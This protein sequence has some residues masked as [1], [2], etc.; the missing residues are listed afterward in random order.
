MAATNIK[1]GSSIAADTERMVAE[2][3]VPDGWTA[4]SWRLRLRQM[5]D[6]CESLVP[7]KAVQLRAWADNIKGV[8]ATVPVDP[9][10]I[11]GLFDLIHD[12]LEQPTI[13]ATPP[14]MK[15]ITRY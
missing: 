11:G 9:P 13:P 6:A 12:L 7:D 1:L 5:A 8:P 2:G 10:M 15:V 14:P 3:H 4:E